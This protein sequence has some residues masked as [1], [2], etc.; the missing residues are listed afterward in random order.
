MARNVHLGVGNVPSL[1]PQ[2]LAGRA[3]RL[4]RQ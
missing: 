2:L 3:R 1:L 4:E